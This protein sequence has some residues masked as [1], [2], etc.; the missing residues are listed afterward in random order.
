MLLLRTEYDAKTKRAYVEFRGR[1]SDV[2]ATTIFSYRTT[3]PL[4]KSQLQREVGPS[5]SKK[6]L[7]QQLTKR[8]VPCPIY[9]SKYG[10]RTSSSQSPA[11]DWL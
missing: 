7:P 10:G 2:I 4:T 3:Q 1:D 9:L 5:C 6:G 11:W 8:Q